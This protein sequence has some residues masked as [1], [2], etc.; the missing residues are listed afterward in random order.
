MAC[1]IDYIQKAELPEEEKLR[2][3]SLHTGIFTKA[4]ESKA[5]RAFEGK[6]YTLKQNYGLGT[7]FVAQINNEF[8][9]PV[10]KIVTP[11][12]GQGYLSVNV[13]PVAEKQGEL[14]L[15][16]YTPE[17]VNFEEMLKNNPL[18]ENVLHTLLDDSIFLTGSLALSPQGT[19][20]RN[21]NKRIHDLDLVA[22]GYTENQLDSKVFSLYSNA[23]KVYSYNNNKSE[24]KYRIVTYI[25]PPNNVIVND[26]NKTK[27]RINFYNLKNKKG[28]IVGDYSF[29]LDGT[30]E[31]NGAEGLLLDFFLEKEN[32]RKTVSY[33]LTTIPGKSKTILLADYKNTFEAKKALNRP[34]D[35][36]DELNFQ[37]ISPKVVQLSKDLLNKNRV[38]YQ[39]VKDISVNGVKIQANGVANITQGLVQVI[40]GKEAEALPEEAIHFAVELI[41]QKNPTLFNKLLREINDYKVYKQ[42]LADYGKDP[43]YQ[44]NGKPDIIKLKK[45]AIAKQLVNTII[46][47]VDNNEETQTLQAKAQSWWDSIL[48]FIRNLFVSSGFDKA[49]MDII[50]GKTEGTMEDLRTAE[51]DLFLQKNTQSTIFDKLKEI[52]SGIEKRGDEGYFIDGKKVPRRVSDL[53]QDWYSRR[54]KD[55]GLTK[56][57]YDTAVDDLKAEK[58]TKGHADIE[59]AF[60][61]YV[62]ENG[63]LRENPLEDSEYKSQLNP[64]DNSMYVILRDNLKQRLESFPEGTRFM[65]EI[66]VYDQSRQLGGTIDFLA[67]TPD[68]NV[69][70]LDWKFMD[71]NVSKYTDIP[72]YKINAWNQ[73]M[74]QYKIILQKVYGV[75][76]QDFKQT[77]MIPIKAFYGAADRKKGILPVLQSIKIGDVN[78]QNIT[79]DYLLPVGIE[80]ETTG[81]KK[82]DSLIEKLNAV[83]KKFSDKKVLP[84]EKLSKAEQLNTLFTAIRQL[85]VKGN[86]KPLLYQ[87][88]V[89]NKQ[90]KDT[91][92]KFE[93]NWKGKAPSEFTQTAISDFAED[94]ETAQN[95]IVHY[96]TLDTNLKFLFSG[97]LTEED[98]AL[99][100]ELRDVVD[101]ARDLQTDLSEISNQFVD[102]FVAGSEEVENIL[103]PEKV[104]KGITKWFSSTAT[105]QL[106]SLEVLYKKANRA[107][108]FSSMDTIDETKKLQVLEKDYA[109]WAKGKGLN[110]SNY[111]EY[112]ASI[113]KKDENQLID[114]FNP[115]FYKELT[116]KIKQFDV[117]WLKENI[118]VAAY[119]EH[120]KTKLLKEIE[121]IT[122]KLRVGT[123]E[124]VDGQLRREIAEAKR[125]YNISM[126]DSLG[127]FLREE[128]KLFPKRETWE[129]EKWKFLHKPENKPAL[130]FF[131][132]IKERNQ[133][134]TEIGYIHAKE[135][136]TFLPF[137]RKGLVEKLITSGTKEVTLGEEFLRS[138]S[139]DEGD[140]GYGNTDPLTG[141]L[142]DTIPIY[143]TRKI[144]GALSEDLFRNM[145]LYNEMAIKYKYLSDIEGQVRL[146]L[147]TERNKKA[148]ATSAFGKSVYKDGKLEYTPDNNEN[149]KLLEDM[150][151]GIVYGQKY[152]QSE[153]FD[154]LLGKFGAFGKT[155]N[156]KLGVKIFPENLEGRQLSVNKALTQLNNTFQ[157]NALGLNPLSALS[158]LMGGTFQSIINAGTY[159]TKNDFIAAES[160]LLINKMTGKDQKKMIGAL[161]YFLPLTDNYNAQL[162]KTLSL[163]KL[164]QE[165]IQEFL[166]ILMRKSDWFVQTANFYAFLNNSIVQDGEVVNAREYVRNQPE[167][168]DMFSGTSDQRKAKKVQFEEEVQKLIKEK[169]VLNIGKVEGDVFTIPGVERK[170]QSVV[171]LRRK[172]QQLSKDALG[173]LSEDDLR[174]INMNIFGKSF[175]LFKNWIPRPVDVRIGNLKYNSASD[176]YEWGRMRMVFRLLSSELGNS[177]DSLKNSLSGDGTTWSNQMSELF[178]KK[179]AEYEEETGKTLN[180]TENEFKTLMVKNV[181]A[182]LHDTLFM[183]GLFSLVLGLKALAPDDEED[184][185]VRNSYRFLLRATDK[186]KDELW[187]FYDPTSLT[188][189]VS[190]GVFPSIAY[191]NNFKKLLSNF[192]KENYAI[193]TGNEE[194][195]DKNYVIK[196]LMKSFP[197]SNQASQMLP[198]F[199][200]QLAKDM[201]L[202]MGTESRISR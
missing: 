177:I 89:L 80:G 10:A 38:D 106:K 183:L 116:E 133:Y 179:K 52:A 53:I 136:R 107:F 143:F 43:N 11:R 6:Y 94:I 74:E 2:L 102:E 151:K 63:Y 182:Q 100:E 60:S 158:N 152:I 181:K 7:Q 96:T 194:L 171:E 5:F 24:E 64:N 97:T 84:S 81:N 54:F 69:N 87:A 120:L 16:Q 104:I 127:W 27:G 166:M 9:G 55:K 189:L 156:E 142:I 1:K 198:M 15:Q 119:K 169:G 175:M 114:E 32:N 172:I 48:E 34:K 137:V 115:E 39:K 134:Y 130:D 153:T 3:E 41:Q 72:W 155:F 46:Q 73:Q 141:R 92:S 103:S 78:V 21:G 146:L 193:V 37:R 191:L 22:P 161:E 199:Y 65:S 29:N 125:L 154:Q 88:K 35:Q 196:Y 14:F 71:L 188:S 123:E 202:R 68:G 75:K 70:I 95:T 162:A 148:I 138:I 90:I 85:Q 17:S 178:E 170:S 91:I 79:E 44:L 145:A 49:A 25:I 131:N 105:L 101:E 195:E 112:F 192:M 122:D 83:Y 144:E 157:L 197:V 58:G 113:K 174:T 36:A 184:E 185:R 77:R 26:V 149:S 62:D 124:E 121:R 176:A 33:E 180:M 76:P 20:F 51:N 111:S 93:N 31:T 98:K 61:I 30:E 168:Q 173:N 128:I 200:P 190:T 129:T 186:I 57:E 117:I 118:D 56:S 187:F 19:I 109:T 108:A 147:N 59:H 167:F 82:I 18:A 110:S 28:E 50:A 165:N 23:K 66:V 126:P 99:K 150:I 40:E 132:Y 140:V 13:L 4:K 67:I 164:S 139:M 47:K 45:E 201:G 159:F 86:L 160:W 163:S 42:V 12:P 8:K 135:A